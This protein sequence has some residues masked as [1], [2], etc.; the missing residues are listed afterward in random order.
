M[1]IIF[2]YFNQITLTTYNIGVT[3]KINASAVN[4]ILNASTN[5]HFNRVSNF[6]L[7]ST[8]IVFVL[9]IEKS[10]KKS[11]LLKLFMSS[12]RKYHTIGFV[13]NVQVLKRQMY[14]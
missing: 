10:K 3:R 11:Y 12:V 7:L 13:L 5:H 14:C 1:K 2:S 8:E 9:W 4:D 6:Q